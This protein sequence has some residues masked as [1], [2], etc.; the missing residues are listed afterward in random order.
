MESIA[1]FTEDGPQHPYAG[2]WMRYAARIDRLRDHSVCVGYG[3]PDHVSDDETITCN[4]CFLRILTGAQT[5]APW[6]DWSH[7][8]KTRNLAMR[9]VLFFRWSLP[10]YTM[11]LLTLP[12][13]GYT[14]KKLLGIYVTD[15]DGQRIGFRYCYRKIFRQDHFRPDPGLWIFNGGVYCTKTSSHDQMANCLCVRK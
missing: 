1:S 4:W 13:A 8:Q 15:L 10:G 6:T 14:G 2:F 3:L 12:I 9:Y 11:Q 7:T 5:T